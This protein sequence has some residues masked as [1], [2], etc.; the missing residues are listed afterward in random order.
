[1]KSLLAK[2]AIHKFVGLYLGE[3]E[4]SV[5]EVAVTPFGPVEI[6][7]HSEPCQPNELLATIE[8]VLQSAR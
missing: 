5:S 7:S 6:F 4:I 2:I 3:H 1:M 8:R